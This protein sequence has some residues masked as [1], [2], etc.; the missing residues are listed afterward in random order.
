MSKAEKAK[1]LFMGGANCAQAVCGAV[2][3]MVLVLNMLYGAGNA[4]DKNAKD[5]H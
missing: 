3:G 5:S 2:S 4:G 1:A